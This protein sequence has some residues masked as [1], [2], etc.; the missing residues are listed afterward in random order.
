VPT[1]HDSTER[2]ARSPARLRTFLLFALLILVVY[3]DPLFSRRSFGGRDLGGYSLPIEKAIHDAWSRGRLPVWLADIS[4]GRPLLPNPNS[5]ALYPVRPVLSLLPFPVAMRIFAVLH[6]ILAGFGMI[7]LGESLGL[8]AAGCW[9]GAVTFV[10]SGVSVAEVFYPNIHPGMALLPWMLWALSRRSSPAVRC[11]SVGLVFGLLLLAG[12]IVVCSLALLSA[13][14]WLVLEI[15]EGEQ[16]PSLAWLGLAL[17]LS[18]L[19]AAPQIIATSAWIPLT[20]RAILGMRL[21][22]VLLYSVSPF[23][24]LEFVIPYPFGPTWEPGTISWATGV[25]RGGKSMGLFSGFYAGAFAV[26]A[27][28]VARRSREPGARFGLALFSIAVAASV[29]PSLIPAGLSTGRSPL[30]LR[31]PEKLIVGAVFALSLLAGIA[32]EALL[33]ER[34]APRWPLCAGAVLALVAAGVAVFP[35]FAGRLAFWLVGAE[36]AGAPDAAAVLAPAVAEG[37]LLWMATVI[38]LDLLPRS[39]RV[40]LTCG[41]LL[42]TLVPVYANRRIA[43]TFREEELFAPRPFDRFLRKKDP[44]GSYRT[45]GEPLFRAK[46][47]LEILH[48]GSDPG[49]VDRAIR[50]WEQ[51]S[52]ILWGRGTVLQVDFDHGDLS[53]L[54]SLRGLGYRAS[55]FLDSEP[56]F[57]ALALRWGIRYRD[58]V[59]LGG[60]SSIRSLGIQEW[61][62]NPHA[63]P[64]VRLLEKWR[65]EPA[66]LRV[67]QAL[68]GLGDGE[69]VLETEVSRTGTARGGQ[70]RVLEKTPET[71]IVEAEAAD[72]TWLFVLRGFWPHRQVRVDGLVVEPVPAQIAFSAVPIP[73]G[74]HR[75]EWKETLPGAEV[76][77]WGPV[78]SVLAAAG[79]IIRDRRRGERA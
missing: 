47:Q 71:L 3:A 24:L 61:D 31:Y 43:R 54:E 64:D 1:T 49:G 65:E 55:T 15:P 32:F 27:V 5:G 39:G 75:V 14:L 59:S 22:E 17:L 76:S 7:L 58:Q 2:S 37:A 48:Q 20:N 70:V 38:A 66:P 34:R 56:F 67:I 52:H 51:Y 9:V 13:L 40:P 45:V 19:F 18:F 53:R 10:L 35:A 50:N 6:W 44:E 12:D 57:G 33:R 60:F 21:D 73:A 8:S 79:L 28:V 23:R 63:R 77:L 41:L 11:V 4:G 68:P 26:I 78:V 30:P 62:E 16:K 46:S 29:V 74:R 25:Y 42:L 72:P 69:V 36:S